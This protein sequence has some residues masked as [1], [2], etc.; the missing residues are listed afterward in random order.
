MIVNMLKPYCEECPYIDVEVNTK[1]GVD[2]NGELRLIK[3]NISC[4][5]YNACKRIYDIAIKEGEE[6]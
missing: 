6:K 5:N 4:K 2:K 1:R 3:T